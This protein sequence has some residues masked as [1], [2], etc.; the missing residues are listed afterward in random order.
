[1]NYDDYNHE[2]DLYFDD[3]DNT[4][5]TVNDGS[6]GSVDVNM[7]KLHS[8]FLDKELWMPRESRIALYESIGMDSPKCEDDIL[9]AIKREKELGYQDAHISGLMFLDFYWDSDLPN[10]AKSRSK[11]A[12]TVYSPEDI[13]RNFQDQISLRRTR[14]EY[15]YD[16]D[17]NVKLDEHNHPIIKTITLPPVLFTYD[18]EALGADGKTASLRTYLRTRFEGAIREEAIEPYSMKQKKNPERQRFAYLNEKM[19][20]D[21][22]SE[23][24][25]TLSTEKYS[26]GNYS[27]DGHF[28]FMNKERLNNIKNR[29]GILPDEKILNDIADLKREKDAD[30]AKEVTEYIQNVTFG[31]KFLGGLED[32]GDPEDI[33]DYLDDLGM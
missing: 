26:S 9:E 22:Q 4:E 14:Q 8:S 11:D 15:D 23:F 1:M 32:L 31:Y 7:N 30:K 17:G 33:M 2:E 27:A 20:D 25:D 19:S 18:P 16:K 6:E 12:D 21:G 10:K 29:L 28:D 3:T 13:I 5:I 24:G